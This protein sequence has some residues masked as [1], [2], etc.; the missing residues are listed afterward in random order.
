MNSI[1][2]VILVVNVLASSSLLQGSNG[3]RSAKIA[4]VLVTYTY[5]DDASDFQLELPLTGDLN[6]KDAWV[7]LGFN[8]SPEMVSV[9]SYFNRTYLHLN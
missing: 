8:E 1:V 5:G 4:D 6:A 3:Q 2:W 7:A 9:F